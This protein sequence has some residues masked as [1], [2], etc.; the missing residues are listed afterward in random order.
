MEDMFFLPETGRKQAD[1]T[2]KLS[3]NRK[4]FL[5]EVPKKYG[6]SALK[7]GTSAPKI[8]GI[9][10]VVHVFGPKIKGFCYIKFTK[11]FVIDLAKRLPLGISEDFPV[12]M[13]F[14]YCCID[15]LWIMYAVYIKTGA[16]TVL[17]EFETLPDW[18]GDVRA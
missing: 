3:K 8:K 12:Y 6:F 18:L 2:E 4:F 16:R 5:S 13:E 14:R 9:S 7:H 17:G 1:F 10:P 15:R 11:R